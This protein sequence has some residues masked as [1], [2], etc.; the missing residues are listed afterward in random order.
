M[1]AK[2]YPD[3]EGLQVQPGDGLEVAPS[4]GPEVAPSDNPEVAPS[5]G[6]LPS[7]IPPTAENGVGGSHAYD[8]GLEFNDKTAASA[9]APAAPAAGAQL[10]CGLR[11]RTMWILLAAAIL[12]AVIVA[13]VVG[14]VVGS[15]QAKSR[16]VPPALLGSQQLTMR[17]VALVTQSPQQR[18][19]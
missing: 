16:Y 11:R 9:T 13:S 10:I 8:P 4:D 19:A 15:Q 3:H 6:L 14:G 7:D 2:A 12:V 5:D 18:R 17:A 1:S